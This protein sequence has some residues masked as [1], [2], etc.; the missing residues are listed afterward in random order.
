MSITLSFL[1]GKLGEMSGQTLQSYWREIVAIIEGG[2]KPDP[3]RV[4]LFAEHFAE[5]LE[6]EGEARLASRIRRLTERAA[7]PAGST[8]VTQAMTADVEAQQ[9]LVEEVLPGPFPNY[10]AL[11]PAIEAE[12]KR[13]VELNRL[14]GDLASAGIES[15]CTLLLFG[16]PGCGKTMSAVAVACDL[17]LPLLLVRLD[18]LLGSYLGNSAKNL[19]RVFD[20]ALSKPCVLLLDEFDAVAKM[21]DDAQEVGEVKR[22][23]GSL[24]QNFDRVQ[25]QQIIIAAT[26]H[27][28]MLDPAIWRRFDVTLRLDNPSEAQIAGIVASIVPKGSLSKIEVD[29]V[30]VLSRGMSGSDVT[31]IVKRALQDSFLFPCDPFAKR[32]ILGVLASLNGPG[33]L[34]D[35]PASKKEL[36][37]AI[38]K[39]MGGDLPIRQIAGLVGCSPTYAHEVI[40]AWESNRY[41]DQ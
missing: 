14:S 36:V 2:L 33:G 39:R 30:A 20:N 18:S 34:N 40:A 41:D 10:P 16:P 38:R 7:K 17:G 22:L 31:S 3:Y 1:T 9:S 21:R 15:P 29:A 26:N 19:R 11:P 32:L 6:A 8:F 12:L 37:I 13:F 23:V 4:S 25:G 27:H 5:R 24:L 28:H 35:R